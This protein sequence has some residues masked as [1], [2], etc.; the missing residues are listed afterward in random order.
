MEGYA[1]PAIG[2]GARMEQI[3]HLRMSNCIA[4]CRALKLVYPDNEWNVCHV[5]AQEE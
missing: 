1:D 4:L 3:F 2:Q 5:A